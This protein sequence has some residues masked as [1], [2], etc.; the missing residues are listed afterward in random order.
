MRA[1][2]LAAGFGT[3]LRPLTNSTPKCLIPIKGRPLL[4]IWLHNL[5]GANIGPVL[6]NTHYLFE[7]VEAYVQASSF[8]D[9]VT[10]AH[11]PV[12]L[13]TAG[14]LIANLGFFGGQD[15]LLIHADNYCMADLR[16]F[17]VAHDSRPPDCL[18]TMMT[19]RSDSPQSCGIVE[20]DRNRVVVG[21]HEKVSSPPGNIANAAVYILSRDLMPI[22]AGRFRD[23]VDFSTEILP[24]LVGR[25]FAHETTSLFLDIGTPEAYEL[26]NQRDR[27]LS[28]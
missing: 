28:G 2:L 13:G 10:L 4:D 11:E 20:L 25:M 23:A 24:T 19:F 5:S 8:K 22:L 27:G 9:L 26:A 21:F 15:G 14:T 6:V 1:I 18:M 12:L 16:E 3:R 17:I 7:Q